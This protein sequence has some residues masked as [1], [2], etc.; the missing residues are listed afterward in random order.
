M[1][2][3]SRLGFETESY[4]K[5]EDAIFRPWG[6]ILVT[7]PTGSGKTNT[8]Y[9]AISKINTPEVNIMTVEDPVEF[10][11]QGI[12][13]VQVHENIGLSFASIL[14]SFLRQDPNIILVGEIRDSETA[15]IAVK[16][17]L[18]GH[19]V[20]STLHTNDASSAVTR[21]VD[22]GVD[23]FLVATSVILIVAQRLVRR[24]CPYCKTESDV[25]VQTLINIGFSP[26]EA[27]TVKVYK[28]SGCERCGKTG[29]K[30]RIGLFEVL[31]ITDP[32]KELIFLKANAS[33]ISKKAVE[34]GML[35]LRQS[36]LSKIKEG[37]TTIEEVIRE[38]F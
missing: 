10:N 21:L 4:K 28:P 32:I 9:S 2:D 22:M 26:E 16:A 1:P 14:R 15:E 25:S 33:E 7:G 8:L 31:K 19:L 3:L 36:G 17:S 38:T 37:I 12:N 27:G 35:I 23:S 11:I 30:G 20:L 5:F 6:M 24:L 13:Q 18:T 34:E 29:Y